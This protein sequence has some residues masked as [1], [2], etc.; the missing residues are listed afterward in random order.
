MDSDDRTQESAHPA[1]LASSGVTRLAYKWVVEGA[2]PGSRLR[3]ELTKTDGGC[4]HL[5]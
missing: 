3:Q 1:A 4:Q 5:S 2:C